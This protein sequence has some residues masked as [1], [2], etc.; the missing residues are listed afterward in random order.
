MIKLKIVNPIGDVVLSETEISNWTDI[1]R[2]TSSHRFILESSD[3]A[4]FD[5][6]TKEYIELPPD[7]NFIQF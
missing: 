7:Y 5:Y 4:I 2:Y 1:E 6:T 3:G